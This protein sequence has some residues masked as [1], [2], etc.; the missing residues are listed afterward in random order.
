MPD[1]PAGYII[2]TG[3][4]LWTLARGSDLLTSPRVGTPWPT[5]TFVADCRCPR[6]HGPVEPA[7]QAGIY[8]FAEAEHAMQEGCKVR[9]LDAGSQVV[10]GDVELRDGIARGHLPNWGYGGASEV[11]G[12]SATIR[13][14]FVVGEW[15]DDDPDEVERRLADRYLV[16]VAH[17]H[18]PALGAH[19][20]WLRTRVVWCP[21]I[22]V[23]SEDD[24]AAVAS[25]YW[26]GDRRPWF[27]LMRDH[28]PVIAYRG[29][30]L[31][32]GREEVLAALR[33]PAFVKLSQVDRRHR[34]L[35]GPALAPRAVAAMADTLREQAAAAIGAV[36]SKGKCEAISEVAFAFHAR[37]L[38]AF[39]GF[40]VTG[41]QWLIETMAAID[42]DVDQLA[43]RGRLFD[44]VAKHYR[45]GRL[46]QLLNG[47]R[48]NDADVL[49]CHSM[50]FFA[51]FESTAAAISW[52]LYELARSPGLRAQL[53]D[54]PAR[55][56]A[57][58]DEIL[59]VEPP[60]E[61]FERYT[62]KLVT[63]GGFT[64]PARVPV[65]L[66][67]GAL[68]VDTGQQIK[69]GDDDQPRHW[70]FG[71]GPHRCPGSHLAAEEL[72]ILITE[73]LRRIPDFELAP[74][75]APQL[76]AARVP[77]LAELP[78]IWDTAGIAAEAS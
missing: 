16:P 23:L 68:N 14:L 8:A 72:R 75:F 36:A 37:A 25:S 69:L 43:A 50:F 17:H 70:T 1:L 74:D 42:A 9:L 29:A 32:T 54:N 60:I 48:L 61:S 6:V 33:N 11:S 78:L 62:A 77:T 58:V 46:T 21:E 71:A 34:R 66:H 76:R 24:V 30:V 15:I 28:A 67:V 3:W 13:R 57:F 51:G 40:P 55:I 5:A 59:R 63:V 39:L 65:R 49:G 7:C 10:V 45:R 47:D 4:R 52:S 19:L 35:S 64:L 2:A 73:W 53:R 20:E 38:L 26:C 31:I 41:W 12:R 22:P 18:D 27:G 56:P 44:Y